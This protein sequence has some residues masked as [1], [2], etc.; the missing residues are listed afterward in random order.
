LNG[1]CFLGCMECRN[2]GRKNLSC[3]VSR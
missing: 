2:K 1:F 3:P